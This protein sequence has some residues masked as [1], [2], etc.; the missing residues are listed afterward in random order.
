MIR[1]I[2]CILLLVPMMVFSL[3]PKVNIRSVLSI[4][5]VLN[6]GL[7]TCENCPVISLNTT[8]NAVNVRS[9]FFFN[10]SS[11]VPFSKW[12]GSFRVGRSSG[13]YLYC[14]GLH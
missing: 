9:N 2:L 6:K 4:R 8:D 7:I 14:P 13:E 10:S 1:S 12:L 5:S 3:G 11:K